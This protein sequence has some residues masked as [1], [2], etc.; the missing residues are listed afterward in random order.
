MKQNAAAAASHAGGATK[1]VD[2]LQRLVQKVGGVELHLVGHSAGSIILGHML[3]LLAG[4]GLKAQTCTLYAPACSVRFALEYYGGARALD[5]RNLHVHLLSDERERDDTVGPYRK[6]LLYL[7][8]RAL[9]SSHKM[10]LLGMELVFPGTRAKDVTKQD[11]WAD[12]EEAMVKGWHEFW[13]KGANLHVL[14]DAQVSTGRRGRKIKAAHGSF[15][16][17]EKVI[18]DTLRR[19]LGRK[20][21]YAVECLDY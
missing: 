4:R 21:Q 11:L 1:V 3:P 9:E 6:S 10:P 20:P 7:V 14:E 5:R 19:I 2:A 13:G 15:D 17:D 12:E 8:S 16:N 18:L